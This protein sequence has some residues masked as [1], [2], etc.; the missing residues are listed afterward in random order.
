M[1]AGDAPLQLVRGDS[2]GAQASGLVLRHRL[3]GY[4]EYQAPGEMAGWAE[5]LWTYRAP[6]DD[7]S[8]HRILPDPAISVAFCYTRHP[9][10]R[11]REPRIMVFGPKLQPV[12][13]R[14]TPGAEIVAVKLKLEWAA[15]VLQL[16]PTDHLGSAHDMAD[17]HP[18][19][20]RRLLDGLTES[21]AVGQALDLLAAGIA[22]ATRHL[23][24]RK[25]VG[26]ARAF[27]LVRGSSGRLPVERIASMT[28]V[29]LR[30]LRRAARRDSGVPL[31]LYGRLLRLSQ[32]MT[33]TDRLP[34]GAPAEWARIAVGA[35]YYDQPHLIRECRAITGMAPSELVRE[36]RD[37]V[38][39]GDK[40]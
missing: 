38:D 21:R 27:D 37:E 7:E 13:S 12:M 30:H 20:A 16:V 26:A 17:I 31:K 10:G 6:A 35:G 4:R 5:A 23:R 40:E 25:T 33:S 3:G 8:T 11:P 14:Y 22:R 18:T 34:A 2:R 19:L 29:S 9:D 39:P 32:A 24:D 1:R 15:P 36:R 28:G